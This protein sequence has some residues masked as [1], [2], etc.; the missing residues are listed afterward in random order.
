MARKLSP[1]VS[2]GPVGLLP[3]SI[4][5]LFAIFMLLPLGSGVANVTMPNLVLISVF[6]WLSSRPLLMPYG[7]CAGVGLALDFWLDVPLGLN[8][9]I[10]LMARLFVLGQSKHYR[11]RNRLLYWAVFSVM[12]LGL[13]AMSWLIMAVVSGQIWS[14]KPLFL[15]W[16]VTAFSYAPVAFFLGRVRRWM[17]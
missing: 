9:L 1:L 5:V 17:Q 2:G 13:Y 14:V 3:L 10:L 16:L 11:G 15:Q 8:M 6:Y 4:T 7:A 12:S